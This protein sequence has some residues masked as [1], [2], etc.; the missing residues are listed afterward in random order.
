MS[1]PLD[2]LEREGAIMAKD[3]STVFRYRFESIYFDLETDPYKSLAQP[4]VGEVT[5]NISVD[6][7]IP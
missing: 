4:R 6:F 3:F 2:R 1:A 7:V 5:V